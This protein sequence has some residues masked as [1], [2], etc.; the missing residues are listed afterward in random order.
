M[1]ISMATVG[2]DEELQIGYWDCRGVGE[3]IRMLCWLV[4]SADIA[5]KF[6]DIRYKAPS[7]LNGPSDWAAVEDA[8][9]LDF[10]CLPYCIDGEIRMTQVGA[11]MRHICRRAEF[12][13]PNLLGETLSAQAQCDQVAEVAFSLHRKLVKSWYDP[14]FDIEAESDILPTHLRMLEAC[15]EPQTG[16]A[17][18]QEQGEVEEVHPDDHVDAL[19]E[20]EDPTAFFAGPS[21]TWCDLVVF[22]TMDQALAMAPDCLTAFPHLEAFVG[23]MEERLA[24]YLTSQTPYHKPWPINNPMAAFGA[25][26]APPYVQQAR[27]RREA[28]ARQKKVMS[29][30][31]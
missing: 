4:Q 31:N 14:G 17:P 30:K 6:K 23:L 12:F 7:G 16:A 9:A 1:Q 15:L 19:E 24:T 3:P 10:P 22:E 8:M 20:P 13:E 2:P 18:V 27:Q 21:L 25:G 28:R 29:T 5:I 26:R 11:I